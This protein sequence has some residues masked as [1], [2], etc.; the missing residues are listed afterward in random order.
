M[1][2]SQ[3]MQLDIHSHRSHLG[4]QIIVNVHTIAIHP[5]NLLFPFDKQKFDLEWENIKKSPDLIYAIGECGLDRVRAGIANIDEQKYVLLK[6]FELATDRKLPIILHTVRA[7]SDL[8]EIL[9]KHKFDNPLLLHDYGGNDH[10][11]HRLLK[12]PVY[13]SYGKRIFFNEKMLK[14]T[15]LDRLLLETGDQDDY[16]IADIYQKASEILGMS[17][18]DLET[19]LEK[20]FLTFFNKLDDVGASNFIQDLNTRKTR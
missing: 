14:K 7:F 16:S 19:Q 9:K 11:M 3:I 17:L 4:T 13:F 20:N 12:Y 6:H 8:L 5:W 18:L 15:P 2:Y 10:E 1:N